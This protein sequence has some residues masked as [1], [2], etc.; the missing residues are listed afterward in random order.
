MSKMPAK[1]KSCFQITSVTQAQVAANNA[2]DDAESQDDPDESRTEDVSSEIFDMSRADYGPEVCDRSSS[3]ETLN[4]VGESEGQLPAG[5]PLNGGFSPRNLGHQGIQAS[6]TQAAQVI[7]SSSATTV[8][9]CSSRFR[10]I[11]LDHGTGEPFRRGRWTCMEYYEKDPEGS[12]MS[13]TVDSIRHTNV[14]EPGADRDSGLGATVGSVMAQVALDVSSD[15]SSFTGPPH[16]LELHMHGSPESFS[17][18]PVPGSSHVAVPHG[19]HDGGHPGTHLQKSPS[20]PPPQ[21]QPLLYQP[22]PITHQLQSQP[23]L[24]STS[25][26]DYGLHNMPITVTQTL[27]GVSLSVGH[28]FSQGSSPLPTPATGGVQVL[29][30]VEM[31]GVPGGVPLGSQPVASVPNLVQ[32]PAV[33]LLSSIVPMVSIQQQTV[34]QYQASGVMHGLSTTPQ[35]TLSLPV[36]VG[37]ML[38]AVPGSATVPNTSTHSHASQFPRSG[39]AAGTGTSVF[40]QTDESQ[41]MSDASAQVHSKDMVKPLITEGLQFPNPVVNS[42]FGIPIPIDGEEDR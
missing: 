32:H 30:T 9:S 23:A 16:N 27:P 28:A 37:G 1:K 7:S 22:Q 42:L 21:V 36:A 20:I 12:V 15:G 19:L 29:G 6:G 18:K 14:T 35:S 41:R 34:A 39:A 5:A 26:P 4:N 8:T 11:K 33:G 3:E 10:V 38:T 40:S 13:R 24:I 25:Q 17:N 31:S 2:T